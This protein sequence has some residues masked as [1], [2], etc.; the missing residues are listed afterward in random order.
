MKIALLTD[1]CPPA[2]G[3]GV[4][5]A[6]Y[7]LCL[8]LCRAGFRARIFTF[9]D[10]IPGSSRDALVRRHGP[11]GFARYVGDVLSGIS[12][13]MKDFDR[14]VYQTSD[15][16]KTAPGALKAAGAIR[17]FRP[18]AVIAQDQGAP[19]LFMARPEGARIIL[20]SHHNPA[21]FLDLPTV[22]RHSRRDAAAALWLERRTLRKVDHVVCPTRY[23]EES[24]RQSYAY[25]GPIAVIPNAVDYE[26]IAAVAPRDLRA[27]LGLPA[28]A[29]LV[30]VPSA[31]SPYKGAAFIPELLR[32]CAQRAGG[33]I[34]FYLSGSYSDA[35]REANAEMPPAVRLFAPGSLERFANLAVVKACDICLSPTLVENFSMAFLEANACGLPVVTFD[36]GG[37]RELIAEG[38]SGYV[39][40]VGSIAELVAATARLFERNHLAALRRETVATIHEKVDPA[41]IAVQYAAL[42]ASTPP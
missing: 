7:D 6:H 12:A 9:R 10:T 40:P 42:C 39:V 24:F 27:E 13:R 21:R 4:A 33:P 1:T 20:V 18:D 14:I 15:I 38:R 29:P 17:A 23:M 32:R 35:L 26:A 22:R 37:N 28:E 19:L 8:A 16:L 25:R 11:T 5:A 30:Y 2:R 34:G 41:R 36:V 31:G 3:A